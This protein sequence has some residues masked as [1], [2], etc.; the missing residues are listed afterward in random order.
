LESSPDF[1]STR[2]TL[3]GSISGPYGLTFSGSGVQV[4]S[5]SNT[6]MGATLAGGGLATKESKLELC[7]YFSLSQWAGKCP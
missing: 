4:L 2:F 6:Y 7:P 1:R 5:G 3:G